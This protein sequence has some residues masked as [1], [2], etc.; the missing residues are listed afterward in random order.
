MPRSL[1]LV[2]N[3]FLLAFNLV[4]GGTDRYTRLRWSAQGLITDWTNSGLGAGFN[5]VREDVG[6]T[7]QRVMALND[8]AALFF[9]DSIYRVEYIAQP[10]SFGL[11]PLPRGRRR[12]S[13]GNCGCACASTPHAGRGRISKHAFPFV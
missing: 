1:A 2:S 3:S 4:D 10:A 11:R 8:Y 9:T 13:F 12:L 5:D 7:G 6:G